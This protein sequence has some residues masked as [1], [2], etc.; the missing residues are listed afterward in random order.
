MAS[1]L[2]LMARIVS[3]LPD[4]GDLTLIVLKGHLILEEE[5]NAA[6]AAKVPDPKYVLDAELEFAQLLSVAK[7]FYFCAADAWLWGSIKKLNSIR[8][9]M[10]HTLEPQGVDEKLHELVELVESN[11]GCERNSFAERLRR[12]IAM[13]A[14][15]V[16]H[17]Y[18]P[19][20]A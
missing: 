19:D 8:N 14:A 5:L 17:L 20:E 7:A 16:R 13:L 12:C 6:V 18:A 3:H 15:R 9:A 2:E 10:A 4:E 1:V 11:I